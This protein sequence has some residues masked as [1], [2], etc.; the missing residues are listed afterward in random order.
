MY[1]HN[2]SVN[3][4]VHSDSA[5]PLD[6]STQELCAAMAYHLGDLLMADDAFDAFVFHK[7]GIAHASED[8]EPSNVRSQS[9]H[10]LP[11]LRR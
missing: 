2:V 10:S 4:K 6:L 1:T 11:S 9:G 7:K 3:F 8:H 5:D